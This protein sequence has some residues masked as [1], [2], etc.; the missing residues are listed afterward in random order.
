[1]DHCLQRD[2]IERLAAIAFVAIR[3]VAAVAKK[4]D[5]DYL[6]VMSRRRSQPPG[7]MEVQT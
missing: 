7:S 5:F 2:L 6:A 4:K 1:L 3:E